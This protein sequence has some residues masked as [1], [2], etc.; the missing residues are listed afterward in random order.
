MTHCEA[1]EACR[2]WPPLDNRL[3]QVRTYEEMSLVEIAASASPAAVHRRHRAQG[4]Q[5]PLPAKELT[6]LAKWRKDLTATAEYAPTWVIVSYRPGPGLRYHGGLAPYRLHGRREDRF[7]WHDL[8]PGIAAQIT[9]AAS[10]GVASLTGMPVSTTHILLRGGGD[11]GGEQV[12]AR[13]PRPSRP[14]LLAW[15]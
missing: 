15:C 9:A 13:R 3:G 1:G 14:Y 10:I 2:P 8:Q 7:L 12:G 6:D 11:H 4:L 5:L